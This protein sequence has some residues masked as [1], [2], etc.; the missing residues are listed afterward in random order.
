[1]LK[2]VGNLFCWIA[3]VFLCAI[4]SM[5]AAQ[6][7]E[8]QD[9][10]EQEFD[11]D[12]MDDYGRDLCDAAFW[13]TVV[14]SFGVEPAERVQEQGWRG[15]R[16]FTINGYSS[17]MPM[18]T[19]L[20]QGET[21]YGLPFNLVLEVRGTVDPAGDETGVGLRREGWFG[22]YQ[23]AAT[24]Q[25]LV[26]KAPVRQS[27]TSGPSEE[28]QEDGQVD[29]VICLHAWVTVTESLTDQGVERRIRNACGDDPLF[30]STY[31]MSAHALRGF[32]HCN[33]LDPGDYRNESTQLQ[34]CLLLQ[35]EDKVAAAEVLSLIDGPPFYSGWG[36]LASHLSDDVQL[37]LPDGSRIEGATRVAEALTAQSE[38]GSRYVSRVS[39]GSGR[40]QAWGE[41]W[42]YA[43]VT[44]YVEYEQ[45]WER[46]DGR[47]RITAMTVGQF[48]PA[49]ARTD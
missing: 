22:L 2:T 25:D 7:P 34:A 4:S 28:V 29:V 5:A 33:H 42:R 12:C 23:Q 20:S 48:V 40:V 8:A 43:E 24:I 21:D 32:P 26:A 46:I 47:W 9:V 49:P 35:G 16:V 45:T 11:R 38:L 44:D 17:D 19:V 6:T 36:S 14:A 30:N 1:M 41:F 3:A 37:A 31:E 27:G 13:S 10:V 39:G 18:V 15:V